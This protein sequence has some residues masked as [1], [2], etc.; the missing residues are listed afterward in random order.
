VCVPGDKAEDRA[1]A[2]VRL[3]EAL[4]CRQFVSTRAIVSGHA[5]LNLAFTAVLFNNVRRGLHTH[6]PSEAEGAWR[7][8]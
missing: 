1:R 5:R 4:D 8:G 6:A 3:A 7:P 2:V